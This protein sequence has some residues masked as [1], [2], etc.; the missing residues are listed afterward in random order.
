MSTRLYPLY[1]KGSPQLR[2]FL[3]NFWMKMVQLEHQEHL[4][5]QVQFIVSSEMTR[6]DVKNYLEQIYQVPVMDV[7]TVNLTGKTHQHR[8]LGFLHKDDDQ[9]VA[10]V[11]LPKDT[12]F[13][14]PD[15]LA[16]GE[17][18]QRE[19][20]TMDEFKDAQKAFKQGTESKPGREGLPSFFGY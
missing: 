20:Q 18:D 11:T 16:M 17:R 7:R 9:K 12:K 2:V 10:F 19:Q 15:I 14:F 5:N 1:R 6:L 13:E 4:P 3:P 8:Q